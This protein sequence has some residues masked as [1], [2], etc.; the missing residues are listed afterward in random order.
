MVKLTIPAGPEALTPEWL[1]QALRQTN[2]ITDAAVT[3]FNSE[4]IAEGVGLMGRLACVTLHYDRPKVAA[5]LA[6]LH[7]HLSGMSE[8]C[9]GGCQCSCHQQEGSDAGSP[10]EKGT[11]AA[12]T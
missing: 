9:E 2:I 5:P 11:E 1:T 7:E 12:T 6:R 3:S 10:E 4:M 8:G